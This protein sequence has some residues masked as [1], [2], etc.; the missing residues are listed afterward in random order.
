MALNEPLATEFQRL[1]KATSFTLCPAQLRRLI[2]S[3]AQQILHK[4]M[5][6]QFKDHSTNLIHRPE[7]RPAE[8]SYG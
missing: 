5:A 2:E 4:F 7:R 3:F 1:V 8:I 6:K